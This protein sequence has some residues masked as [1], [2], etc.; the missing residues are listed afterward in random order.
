MSDK[1]YNAFVD[2]VKSYLTTEELDYLDMWVH[3][4][5][6]QPDKGHIL[7]PES[8]VSEDNQFWI[9]KLVQLRRETKRKP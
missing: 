6:V 9:E 3:T 2:R 5:F 1:N 4:G 7:L 8:Q